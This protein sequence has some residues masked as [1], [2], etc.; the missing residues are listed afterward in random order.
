MSNLNKNKVYD[1]LIKI[2][3]KQ[4]KILL[5][6]SKKFNSYNYQIESR[7]ELLKFLENCKVGVFTDITQSIILNN[8]IN[9]SKSLRVNFNSK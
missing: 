6:E 3:K 7:K 9:I 8:L 2:T 4:I 5:K 1:K